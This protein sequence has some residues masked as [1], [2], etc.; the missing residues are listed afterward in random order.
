MRALGELEN[1]DVVGAPTQV[2][3]RDL[4]FFLFVEAIGKCCRCWLVDDSLNRQAGDFSRV[5]RRL[6][7]GVVEVSRHGDDRV[8]YGFAKKVF[9]RSFQA[10]QDYPR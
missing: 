3:Y 2:E 10:L 5:F 4:L 7:L 6:A 8:G 9:R 1:R